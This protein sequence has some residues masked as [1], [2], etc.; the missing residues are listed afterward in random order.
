MTETLDSGSL[1]PR[2]INR[3]FGI[4]YKLSIESGPRDRKHFL[5]KVRNTCESYIF[6]N[7][8]S[9]FVQ[10]LCDDRFISYVYLYSEIASVLQSKLHPDIVNFFFLFLH[11]I[12]NKQQLTGM[13]R[14][15]LMFECNVV[16][17]I[18]HLILFRRLVQNDS[19]LAEKV[20]CVLS[21]LTGL[22]S[23]SQEICARFVPHLGRILRT[24]DHSEV[25]F[26]A[27]KCLGFLCK[28]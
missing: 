21:V 6:A 26:T 13:N 5:A 22:S 1:R 16:K 19:M 23:F 20:N 17:L 12:G 10:N 15:D 7:Q 3:V 28:K 14:T 9:M 4:C 27:I 24:I 11:S 18:N 8:N 25:S 2:N